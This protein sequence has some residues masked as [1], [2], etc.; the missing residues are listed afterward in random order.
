MS[1]TISTIKTYDWQANQPQLTTLKPAYFTTQTVIRQDVFPGWLL[2]HGWSS[3]HL[4][5]TLHLIIWEITGASPA[6]TGRTSD[7]QRSQEGQPTV[8]QLGWL[9][10]Y[11]TKLA[12]VVENPSA[13]YILDGKWRKHENSSTTFPWW[14][15]NIIQPP[16][17]SGSDTIMDL[18]PESTQRRSPTLG[19][20]RAR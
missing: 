4:Q 5:G 9:E 2:V 13:S 17:R 19:Q 20:R 14:E 6:R 1:L 8:D 15:F 12:N 10:L 3:P 18:R 16:T 7:D 11:L